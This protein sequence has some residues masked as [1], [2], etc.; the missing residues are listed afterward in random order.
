MGRALSWLNEADEAQREFAEAYRLFSEQIDNEGLAHVHI[1]RGTMYERQ[2]DFDRALIEAEASLRLA[3]LTESDFSLAKALNNTGWYLAQLGRPDEA[4]AH[5]LEALELHRRMGNKR[6]EYNT[7]DSIGF[8]YLS[9]K[10]YPDAQR[11]LSLALELHEYI[12]DRW[13]LGMT[14]KHLGETELAQELFDSS[15]ERWT[16]SRDSMAALDDPEVKNLDRL[17]AM[18]DGLIDLRTG[19]DTSMMLDLGDDS[20]RTN[21][22]GH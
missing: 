3:R 15:R 9:L 5:C 10:K 20:V 8:A 6:G 7:L 17:L 4:L 14:L 12:G 19:S 2:G 11:Y 22:P 13:G 16:A 18:L 21:E 1:D